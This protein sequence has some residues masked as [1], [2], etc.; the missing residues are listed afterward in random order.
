MC[1]PKSIVSWVLSASFDSGPEPLDLTG[2]CLFRA[3][4]ELPGVSSSWNHLS[5]RVVVSGSLSQISLRCSLWKTKTKSL[6]SRILCCVFHDHLGQQIQDTLK[7]SFNVRSSLFLILVFNNSFLKRKIAPFFCNF[8]A[9]IAY[10]NCL[11]MYIQEYVNQSPGL[12]N[13]IHF[14]RN[15]KDLW[16][17]GCFPCYKC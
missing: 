16:V 14:L 8:T 11:F 4:M 13:Q 2:Q 10:R 15:Q 7:V 5:C 12:S 3:T 9:V 1:F 6:F 17:A